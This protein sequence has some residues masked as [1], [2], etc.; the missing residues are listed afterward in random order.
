MA[1]CG[2]YLVMLRKEKD[3]IA[4]EIR[5]QR[6]ASLPELVRCMADDMMKKVIAGVPHYELMLTM[7]SSP[8]LF[9]IMPDGMLDPDHSSVEDFLEEIRPYGREKTWTRMKYDYFDEICLWEKSVRLAVI[10]RF[11]QYCGR[12]RDR[13]IIAD[14]YLNESFHENNM[15]MDMEEVLHA[16]GIDPAMSVHSFWEKYGTKKELESDHKIS[17]LV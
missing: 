15:F 3:E 2:K 16:A 10:L 17:A 6:K 1:S 7:D 5:K 11:L 12:E 13:G 14:A 9:R 8:D 4:E